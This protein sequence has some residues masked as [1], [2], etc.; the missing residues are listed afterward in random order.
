MDG[1][2]GFVVDDA[3]RSSVRV[4]G[5][6]SWRDGRGVVVCCKILQGVGKADM[7]GLLGW[8]VMVLR[9]GNVL[10]LPIVIDGHDRYF[11]TAMSCKTSEV[12]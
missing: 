12:S 8:A 11:M 4:T 6:V 2:C 1:G 5:Y 10:N 3:K 7:D 9:G